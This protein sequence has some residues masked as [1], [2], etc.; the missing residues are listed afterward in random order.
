MKDLYITNTL[1]S[2]KELLKTIKPNEVS[3]Y[4]CG[5]T[6]Y[7][8]AH[9][10]HAR[11]YII[12]DVFYRLLTFLGYKTTYVRNFTDID[13]KLIKKAE[14]EYGD[15]LAYKKVADKYIE[16]FNNDLK[17]LGCIAPSHEPRV[18]ETIKEIIAFIEGLIEK[19]HAY[20][21]NGDVYFQI[22]TFPEY[23]KLSK[24]QLDQLQAGARVEV[25]DKKK[26]P[27]DFALWKSEKEETFFK[28][29]WGYGRPGW[30]IECSAMAKK[31][32]ADQIDIHAGGMD[33]IFPHH[34]NEIAQSEGLSSKPFATYWMHNA[35]VRIDQEKMSKSLGN[36]FTIQQVVKEFDPMVLRY[37]ILSH[38]YNTPLDFSF[39]ELEVAQRSYKRLCKA[40]ASAPCIQLYANHEL[41][42]NIVI[43]KMLTFLCDDLN[44]P[45]MFGVLFDALTELKQDPYKLCAV[46]QFMKEILG[47]TLES[48][49]EKEIELT[50]QIKE[51]IE[52]REQARAAKDWARADAIRDQLQALG[53][54]VH[55]IKAN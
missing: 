33:L 40:F 50:P 21:V 7:D 27:L 39:E 38:S 25:S 10:G 31:Y 45:G 41:E 22:S 43:E 49:P 2:N 36:F 53:I 23:G 54:D 18:T 47:L 8:Y 46:K 24:Q 13:D 42:Q 4:V 12:F 35:F 28:S 32:L 14:K 1:S 3:L 48:L 5:I 17:Q 34:E 26:N 29:P 19:G 44:T 52:Q 11:V 55:D 51:L 9:I 20:Q 6:P 37:F 15:P 30:H 16:A